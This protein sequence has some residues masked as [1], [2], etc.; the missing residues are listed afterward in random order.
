MS[1][2]RTRI[3]CRLFFFSLCCP[4]PLCT[5][6]R[7]QSLTS[8]FFPRRFTLLVAIEYAW[9]VY[10]ATPVSSGVL[11]ASHLVLLGALFLAAM[12]VRD[13]RAA[14]TEKKHK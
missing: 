8:L 4:L 10:P 13:R 1:R 7:P 11:H 14:V 5:A 9:N 12:P 3:F 6:P 2:A